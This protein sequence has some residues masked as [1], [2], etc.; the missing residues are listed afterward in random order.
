M[1]KHVG[2]GTPVPP[3][4]RIGPAM[5]FENVKGYGM[6][7]VTGVLASR[8]RTALLHEQHASSGCR[9]ICWRR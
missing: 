4:T 2:A 7:V 6:P 3:P 9:S 1:Y 8:E 5:L